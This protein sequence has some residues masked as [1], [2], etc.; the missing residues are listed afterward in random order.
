MPAANFRRWFREFIRGSSTDSR[1]ARTDRGMYRAGLGKRATRRLP[2][3]SQVRVELLEERALLATFTVLNTLDGTGPAPAGSL[4][5]A[6]EQANAT[7]GAD[8]IEFNIPGAGPHT[9]GLV[10]ALPDILDSGTHIDG[11]TQPGYVATPLVELNGAAVVGSGLTIRSGGNTIRALAINRFQGHGILVDGAGATSNSIVGNFLG[12][13]AAGESPLPNSAYGILVQGAAANNTIGG[14]SSDDCNIVS[15]N[16]SGGIRIAGVDTNANQVLGNYI[17]TNKTATVA[18]S[19]GGEGVSVVFSAAANWIGGDLPGEGNVVSGNTFA[20][21]AVSSFATGTEIRGNLVGLGAD[22]STALPN[23]EGGVLIQ[24]PNNT[25]GSTLSRNVISENVAWGI[26]VD[27]NGTGVTI[28]G[29]LIGTDST[30]KLDR[31]NEGF[32]VWILN[33]TGNTIGGPSSAHRNVISGNEDSGIAI[34]GAPASGNKVQG[35][36]IGTDVD[37]SFRIQNDQQGVIVSSSGNFIGS[38]LDSLNDENEGNVISGNVQSG[39]LLQGSNNSVSGNL[40]GLNAVGDVAIANATTTTGVDAGVRILGANNTV[41]GYGASARNVISGNTSAH[42]VSIEGTAATFNSVHG[43]FIGTDLSGSFAVTNASGVI[44]SQGA[45]NNSIGLEAT[46]GPFPTPPSG[47]VVSGSPNANSTGISISNSSNNNIFSNLIGTDATGSYALGHLVGISLNQG[48]SYTTIGSESGPNTI[49]GNRAF[50]VFGTPAGVGIESRASNT[51]IDSN[52]IGTDISGR[53]AI[54]NGT[55]IEVASTQFGSP[56]QDLAIS[57]NTISGNYGSGAKIAGNVSNGIVEFSGNHVGLNRFGEELGNGQTGLTIV[58]TIALVA[59]NIISANGHTAPGS[60]ST[61]AGI[62]FQTVTGGSVKNNI[63]GL[64]P[65]GRFARSNVS[66]GVAV[67]ASQ[68]V[69]IG[70]EGDGANDALEG[71]VISGNGGAAIYSEAGTTGTS[72]RGNKIGTDISGTFAIGNN[73]PRFANQSGH[74][75]AIVGSSMQIGENGDAVSVGLEKNVISGNYR[76]GVEITDSELTGNLIGVDLTGTKALPNRMNGVVATSSFVGRSGGLNGN[77]I[78]GNSE[79]GVVLLGS[80]S[81]VQGNYIGTDRTRTLSI[82][83]GQNGVQ[84]GGIVNGTLATGVEDNII[85]G[86]SLNANTIAFNN[87]AGIRVLGENAS[88]IIQHNLY[89]GNATLG[90]DAGVIGVSPNE[91]TVSATQANFPVLTDAYLDGNFMVVRGFANP[92]AGVSIYHANPNATGFGEGKNIVFGSTEGSPTDLDP[93]TG[94]YSNADFGGLNVANGTITANRFEYRFPVPAGVQFGSRVTAVH[95]G[96]MGQSPRLSEFGN[97]ILVGDAP[98]FTV[99]GSAMQAQITLPGLQVVQQGEELRIAGS[100]VDYDSTEWTGRIDFGDGTSKTV[101]LREDF[102]FETSHTYATA[103]NFAVTM[104]ITD[105]ALAQGFATMPV[106]V[107]NVAPVVDLNLVEVTSPVNE[108]EAVKLSGQFD[109]ARNTEAHLVT[110]QWGDGQTSSLSLAPGQTEFSTTHTYASRGASSLLGAGLDLYRIQV[111]VSDPANAQDSTPIG[112]MVAEVRN[113]LPTNLNANF[114]TTSVQ[115]GQ[116]VTITGGSFSDLGLQDA[117]RVNVD[118]GD[119]SKST[120]DLAPGVST[121]GNLSHTYQTAPRVGST[122]EITLELA[123]LDQPLQPLQLKQEITVTQ[124]PVQSLSLTTNTTSLNEGGLILLGATFIEP[125]AAQGHRVSVN[126]GDGSPVKRFDLDPGVTSFSRLEHVYAD[127]SQSKLNGQFRITVSVADAGALNI[128]TSAEALVEVTNVAPAVGNFVITNPSGASANLEGDELVLT[129]QVVDAS[130]LDRYTVDIDW[131]DGTTS[132]AHVDV[133]TRTFSAK[134]RFL[135]QS[136]LIT[137]T[138]YDDEGD[139]S[140]AA[141]VNPNVGNLAPQAT[142][143][144]SPTNTNPNLIELLGQVD[145]VVGD[146]S[147]TYLWSASPIGS[148]VTQLGTGASFTVDRSSAPNSVWSVSLQVDDGE[149]GVGSYAVSFLAGTAGDDTLT[150]DNSTFVGVASN[151]LLV[152][153]LG[154]LDVLDGSG[155][156]DSSKQLILDGGADTDVL[157]GG[158]GD[159]VF[160][161]RQ[162]NDSANVGAT[163]TNAANAQTGGDRYYLVPNSTLTVVDTVGANSLDFALASFGVTFDLSANTTTTLTVQ[164]VDPLGAAGQH[165]VTTQGSFT[166]LSGSDFGDTLTAASQST[167]L[168]G[169]GN[170]QLKVGD[171]T[172]GATL[173]GGA[174]D[175]ALLVS[176]LN[177]SDLSFSG[178]DGIDYLENFGSITTLVFTGGADDD[179]LLND[180]VVLGELNFGGDDGVDYLANLGSIDSLVFTG[181]ADD[182]YLVN[183]GIVLG[184]LNFGGDD[185]TDYLENYYTIGSLV[186]TGGADDDYLLNDGEVLG[187]LSFGG[188]DGVDYLE[189]LGSIDSLVFTGGA[190]DDYLANYDTINS[191]VFT[192]GADDDYL[193]NYDTIDSLVF[194]GG[195]DADGLYNEGSVGELNFGGDDGIDYLENLGSID[196]LIFTGGADDDYLVNHSTIALLTFEGGADDDYLL[197]EGVVLGELNFGGDDG[198]DYLENVGSIASLVFTGGADD[199]YL[200]NEGDVL[201]ELN[202][203]GDDG[204]DYLE[205]LGSIDSLIFTGG[206][207]DDYLL[208]TNAI[209]SLTFNGGADDDYLLNEGTLGDLSF[210]GDSGVDRLY[211]LGTAGEIVFTGG[212]D[213]DYLLNEGV[214]LGEINFGGD[215][216]SDT[217]RNLGIVGTLDFNGGA[218]A[219]VLLN[220]SGVIGDL[221]FAGDSGADL[222]RN[223]ATVGNLVFIGGADDDYLINLGSVTDLTFTGG[224]DDDYLLN[225]GDALATLSFEGDTGVDILENSGSHIGTLVFN[226]GADDDYLLNTGDAIVSLT[227][228]GGADDDVLVSRGLQVGTLNFVGDDSLGAQGADTLVLH[229]SGTE[230]AEVTFSGFGGADVLQNNA[231]GIGSIRFVGGADGDVLQNFGTEVGL[232]DFQGDAGVD[233]LDNNADGLTEIIFI[234]GADDDYLLNDGLAVSNITF[235]GGADDDYLINVGDAVSNIDFGGDD[236]ADVLINRGANVTNILFSGGADAD[237][238]INE[239][240]NASG[241]VFHGDLGD[242]RFLNGIGG[243]GSTGLEFYGDSGADSLVNSAINVGT[244]VFNG[245]ADDDYLLNEGAAVAELS[246]QGDDGAD[247]LLNL[248]NSAGDITFTGGGDDDTLVNVGNSIGLI[249]FNGDD[250]ADLLRNNG[251]FVAS[252]AFTGGAD[253]DVLINNADSVGSLTFEGDAGGDILQNNGHGLGSITFNGGTEDDVLQNNGDR[254]TSLDFVAGAGN[255]RLLNNGHAVR[256]IVFLGESGAD[257]LINQGNVVGEITF[258][259]GDDADVMRVAGTDVGNVTFNGGHGMDSFVYEVERAPSFPSNTVTY[260]GQAGNDLLAWLGTGPAMLNANGGDGDDTFAIGGAGVLELVGGNGD[261]YFVFQGTPAAEVTIGEAFDLGGDGSRDTLD[262]STFADGPLN[263]DLRS[264]QG[265]PQ[266]AGLTITLSDGQGIENVYG[267]HGGDTILGNSRDNVINGAEYWE[268]ESL[269]LAARRA[270][271]QWVLLDFD[272]ATDTSLGEH[273]YTPDERDAI[274][275]NL[276]S[277]YHGPNA[278]PADPSSWWFNVAFTQNLADVASL[279][280]DGYVTI[281]FN[282]TPSFGRPGGEASEVDLGNLNLGGTAFVQVNGLLGGTLATGDLSEK[283]EAALADNEE[284][285]VKLGARKPVATSSNFV[286]LASKI[287]AHELGHLLGLRHFDTYGPIGFGVHSTPG[288]DGYNPVY[289]GPAGAYEAVNHLLGS[290]ASIGTDRFNDL[291]GLFFGEREAVKLAYATATPSDVNAAEQSGDHNSIATAQSLNLV[292]LDVPNTLKAGLNAGKVFDVK[293]AAVIGAITLSAEGMSESDYYKFTG[294]RGEVVNVELSSLSLRGNRTGIDLWIDSILRVTDATG[295]PVSWYGGTAMNDDEFESSDSVIMD[296]VLPYDGEYFIE[297]DSF[298]RLPGSA[299]YE[300]AVALR[301]EL[302]ARSYLNEAE[303]NA[304]IRLQDSLDDTDVGKYHLFLYKFA[305]ANAEDDIDNLKGNGGTDVIN[306]GPGDDF[307]TQLE[308]GEAVSTEVGT[309]FSQAF[310]F[311]DRAASTWTATVDYGDG[312]DPQSLT[313]STN[314]QGEPSFELRHSYAVVGNYTITVSITNDSLTQVTDTL[315]VEVIELAPTISITSVVNSIGGV[316]FRE[317]DAVTVSLVA[318]NYDGGADP[319]TVRYEVYKSGAT[320]SFASGSGENLSS[321]AFTPDDNGAYMVTVTVVDVAGRTASTGATV[322]VANVAP[323]ITSMNIPTAADEAS[324]VSFSATAADPGADEQLSY[325]WDFGDGTTANGSSPTHTYA[326]NGTYTVSLTVY[327]KDGASATTSQSIVV[328]NLAPTATLVG[329][330][331]INEGSSAT[332]RFTGASDPADVDLAADLR[333]SFALDPVDLA[334]NYADADVDPAFTTSFNDNG[335]FVIYG[336]VIDKDGG[337]NDYET[338]LI[339]NNVAPTVGLFG[340]TSATVGA[341]VTVTGAVSDPAGTNDP[342]QLTWTVMLDG[343]A[344]DTRSGGASYTFTA[345]A[346]GIYMVILQADDGDSG[347]SSASHTIVFTGGVQNNAPSVSISGRDSVVRGQTVEYVFTASDPDS[348]DQSG[349]F[350]YL[351]NWGDGTPTQTVTGPAEIRLTHTF[352]Q[353]TASELVTATVTDARGATSTSTS[354]SVEVVKWQVQSDSIYPGENILVVGGSLAQDWILADFEQGRRWIRVRMNGESESFRHKQGGQTLIHRIA[355]YGQAGNDVIHV[356]SEINLPSLLDGGAGHDY[357]EAGRGANVLIGGPGNDTLIGEQGRDILIGG[358]GYDLLFGGSGQDLLITGY[359]LFDSDRRALEALL[360]E[361][362]GS[363]GYNARRNNLLGNTSHGSNGEYRLVADGTARTVFDDSDLDLALGQV[364]RDWFFGNLSGSGMCDWFWDL[365]NNEHDEDTD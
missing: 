12:T 179:Y 114:S 345:T 232:I 213:D 121:V 110:I 363:G 80:D 339:V 351:V 6:I 246:F 14:S 358:E 217:L 130:S 8:T 99:P 2:R 41:G 182:D 125:N 307:T 190:D 242:D 222:L 252:L 103:G 91:S 290:G 263:L 7:P 266:G 116:A 325:A 361:W 238:L 247:Y 156:T 280:S 251:R 340:P 272:S 164:D 76:N 210:G 202:F 30:G 150:I 92:G 221:T 277:V 218:D 274:Q 32:G 188:D 100:F 3:A 178:D 138:A 74:T 37:G 95:V 43:N 144:P 68:S 353:L 131:G 149:G 335:N 177:V 176:G 329:S 208:N 128:S 352:E 29:N 344:I 356:Y 270:E 258:N 260:N 84:L 295:N 109:D 316:D 21:I 241:I 137:V 19:N 141:S 204:V 85:G 25:L 196:S 154:G 93:S 355:V 174:D 205:N 336:R 59:D 133:A 115:E 195:A 348:Q 347:V 262:F 219:D 294:R 311:S 354:K 24:A 343:V 35:N 254:V 186:F 225:A 89:L 124:A 94:S 275:A 62:Y 244:L 33:G 145:D 165:F 143:V 53:Y 297:V 333:F 102:T 223:E 283:V 129:G 167:V 126:W 229:G 301:A 172:T 90:I 220:L 64:D 86:L 5:W 230:T 67:Y 268:P 166:E 323:A 44:I 250:G 77:T 148:A 52:R 54:A 331:A 284:T 235:I 199:D 22:G 70:T 207:D 120:V 160:Y 147:F 170:D 163:P 55:G 288:A 28:V 259:G 303:L 60:S 234:G 112:L 253:A 289:S 183:D 46:A 314:A 135:D 157:F 240:L 139:S 349:A 134:H 159:D 16:G 146:S 211:N 63:I 248:G 104:T 97:S 334:T 111:S 11:A 191:L 49:S 169:R 271:T 119:G 287:A 326:D 269:P 117:H 342:L 298:V 108:G 48:T 282:E 245:G 350:V 305:Q 365:E 312:N 187:T 88:N 256:A 299:S 201:G 243:A 292:T 66:A 75:A 236:G 87:Q 320:T 118:W 346:A 173:A 180:G 40:I 364:G 78:S 58:S 322:N 224:A 278:D 47:N 276:S 23:L 51:V 10:D 261:D 105:N 328:V 215:D 13:D 308:L 338:T 4:R 153:G 18:V 175:D 79:N 171:N 61:S 136:S 306:G 194:T 69:V 185:G 228:M 285:A 107:E 122:Y 96:V 302:E 337:F 237:V 313:V 362:S 293:V 273:V 357:I 101:A 321:F 315:V 216:G 1:L 309:E 318:A 17:G 341:T 317:G 239:G 327:D 330:P 206:A 71:N 98:G 132:S 227:F 257:A 231:S 155:V 233:I 304:L 26:G 184:E 20:G 42:G 310:V 193:E 192:G 291:R 82:G 39:V 214:V 319:L 189:N 72:V 123:D 152:L 15:G 65:T 38:D 255:D 324:Q 267:T 140:F 127:D 113:R 142:I 249:N 300:Q 162:G 81:W 360:G 56:W 45:S 281:L 279:P 197:N 27:A 296:L 36:Y 83:N 34:S 151:R 265:Q 181:G 209:G 106:I 212:G 57:N 200:R 198:V 9:I 50:N 264:S 226:G 203:G 161:L 359:T 73:D 332:V 158:A 286:G 168:G 31:G